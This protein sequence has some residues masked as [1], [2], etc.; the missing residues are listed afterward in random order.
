[1][2]LTVRPCNFNDDRCRVRVCVFAAWP[3]LDTASRSIFAAVSS[4]IPCIHVHSKDTCVHMKLYMYTRTRTTHTHTHTYIRQMD[5]DVYV[6]TCACIVVC[7]NVYIH[8]HLRVCMCAPYSGNSLVS[9][10]YVPY[11]HRMCFRV[12]C[13]NMRHIAHPNETCRTS[14]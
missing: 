4:T 8:I 10:I 5:I 12:D 7:V 3:A 1:M 6:C 13:G 9:C 11:L 14:E 2:L